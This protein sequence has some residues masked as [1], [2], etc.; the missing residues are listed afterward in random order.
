MKFDAEVIIQKHGGKCKT[1]DGREVTQ[2]VMFDASQTDH[3]VVGVVDDDVQTWRTT[4]AYRLSGESGFDLIMPRTI[5]EESGMTDS[6]HEAAADAH[7]DKVYKR[8]TDAVDEV[9]TDFSGNFE[10]HEFDSNADMEALGRKVA[11]LVRYTYELDNDTP[12]IDRS[13][14]R[15]RDIVDSRLAPIFNEIFKD[16][17]MVK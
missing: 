17:G 10:P 4:G 8:K 9:F 1:R 7:Q 15:A 13:T 16:F 12:W 2:L 6:R 11:G 5:D 14:Q 3:N